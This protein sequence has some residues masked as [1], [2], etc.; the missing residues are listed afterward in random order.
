MDSNLSNLITYAK[1]ELNEAER[2]GKSGEISDD[3]VFVRLVLVGKSLIGWDDE[4][5]VAEAMNQF[6]EINETVN[7]LISNTSGVMVS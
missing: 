7:G 6:L 4:V 1:Q 2:L 3:E 5:P